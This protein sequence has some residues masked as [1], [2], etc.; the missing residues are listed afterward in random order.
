MKK[1][2]LNVFIVLIVLVVTACNRSSTVDISMLQIEKAIEKVE[3][4]K[5]NMTEAD[6]KAF[7]KEVEEP[8][9]T[10][11]QA[12][13]AGQIGAMKRIQIMALMGRLM[14]VVGEAGLQHYVGELNSIEKNLND[15]SV[16][17]D[18]ESQETSE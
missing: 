14:S 1:I 11:N 16:V 6:W 10:L 13:E 3:K 7:E 18:S 2:I 8:V 17:D 5:K 12:A 15:I 9:K 4:N